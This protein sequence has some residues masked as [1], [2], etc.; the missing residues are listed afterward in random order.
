MI[1]K[2]Q[3]PRDGLIWRLIAETEKRDRGNELA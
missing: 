2:P 3:P 1:N